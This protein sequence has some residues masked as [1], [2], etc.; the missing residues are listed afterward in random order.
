MKNNESKKGYCGIIILILFLVG[1]LINVIENIT[2][3]A[4]KHV[5]LFSVIFVISISCAILI[6]N[7]IIHINQQKSILLKEI[8]QLLQI[9]SI[10][11]ER[12][13]FDDRVEVYSKQKF[14]SYS[15]QMWL[16]NKNDSDEVIVNLK[17][18]WEIN[19][20]I[21]R[22]INNNNFKMN[23]YY[24]FIEKKLKKYVEISSNYNILVE[25]VTPVKKQSYQK[26]IR[27]TENNYN[28][29]VNE[30]Y[31]S[32]NKKS[33]A[34]A[35]INSKIE[36]EYKRKQY[37][38]KFNEI[39]KF[40]NESKKNL[41]VKNHQNEINELLQEFLNRVVNDIQKIKKVDSFEWNMLDELINS[42]NNCIKEVI[43]KDEKIKEYYDSEEFENI[44]EASKLL[45]QSHIE[46]NEY[47][48]QKAES[49]SKLFGTKIVRNETTNEDIYN[50]VRLYKKS[51]TPFSVEVSAAVF[52]SAENNPIEY[53]IKY[54][55]PNTNIYR[56]QIEKLC[57]LIE[58][59]ESLRDADIIINNYKKDY[60]QYIKNVPN[61]ILE[62]DEEGFYARLGLVLINKDTLNI[63]YRFSYT[64]DGGMARRYFTVPMNE[65]NIR[66][67][68]EQLENKLSLKSSIKVQRTL[69]T[70]KLRKQI[71]ER[72]HYTCCMCGNSI[73]VEP[74]L[75]L[76]IDHIVP[77]SKGGLTKADNLQTLC[78]K[79]NRNKG[80]KMIL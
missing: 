9:D 70:S 5:L 26:L 36:M 40:A 37:H 39:I 57:T 50:Y 64:S 42:T 79:C 75:L 31:N 33:N 56:E 24:G 10:N 74:N 23:K 49:I 60:D 11:C 4:S 21:N 44:K 65:D 7:Y 19:N 14:D 38:N 55:Y 73:I 77:V 22:F 63:E 29:A 51:L 1:V 28:E 15:V 53:I 35:K 72:D 66:E 8:L 80:A 2:E 71:K 27:V 48:S 68:I 47:I 20:R 78:W 52:G 62:N 61:Y 59:L 76:E 16:K 6:L 54:F 12:K 3:F 45:M 13:D 69:M 43:K 41:I 46:F 30:Y 58:E 17:N 67:L 34:T 18:K 32:I 25:Y